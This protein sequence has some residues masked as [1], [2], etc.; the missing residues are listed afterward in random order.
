MK[1]KICKN[2]MLGLMIFSMV[3]SSIGLNEVD[4]ASKAT[5][6]SYSRGITNSSVARKKGSTYYIVKGKTAKVYV[7][8]IKLNKKA[9]GLKW[10]KTLSTNS[11]G[12]KI[13][14]LSKGRYIK[15]KKIG[16][17]T[18]KV[19]VK[20]RSTKYIAK[21]SKTYSL[22]VKVVSQETFDKMFKSAAAESEDSYTI[23]FD[24]NGGTD[25][26]K[27]SI[28]VKKGEPYGSL[29]TTTRT[30]I[31]DHG[32]TEI[33]EYY[34]FLG[35]YTNYYD[36]TKVSPSTVPTSSHTLYAHW[37]KKS[38]QE[39]LDEMTDSNG[40]LTLGDTMLLR[41]GYE[42][43][44][45]RVEL[46]SEFTKAKEVVIQTDSGRPFFSTIYSDDRDF[47]ISCEGLKEGVIYNVEQGT[48]LVSRNTSYENTFVKSDELTDGREIL[49][50]TCRGITLSKASDQ[51][52]HINVETKNGDTKTFLFKVRESEDPYWVRRNKMEAEARLV[53]KDCT[54]DLEKVRAI[55][56]E[57]L[58]REWDPETALYYADY[59]SWN[60]TTYA[61]FYDI[62]LNAA[63]IPTET[64]CACFD[65]PL[66]QTPIH[67]NNLVLMDGKLCVL[68]G[69]TQHATKYTV[70][71]DENA[72]C[73]STYANSYETDLIVKGLLDYN[74]NPE[75]TYNNVDYMYLDLLHQGGIT[76]TDEMLDEIC[77]KMA[78]AGRPIWL[79]WFGDARRQKLQKYL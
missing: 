1:R 9:S 3:F 51:I 7:K 13:V 59:S 70:Y 17:C 62:M 55:T 76:P 22:K 69:Q 78:E 61:N 25:L 74:I 21:S 79:D 18:V 40:V 64:R 43:P 58:Y 6:K 27:S 49:W 54:T 28:V 16:S 63:G 48:R 10:T 2:I 42:D 39:V 73:R 5:L 35:W 52:I 53:T 67:V 44:W 36:D 29:P 60:C 19:K 20:T 8:N 31:I 38:T 4:A 37:R 56:S 11:A 33:Y 57:I 32:Y 15:G 47:E 12:K 24:A 14:G 65:G 50:G 71:F 77:D 46:P 45:R 68:D 66:G 75:H 34:E 30:E 26:S 41:L 23:K 72:R